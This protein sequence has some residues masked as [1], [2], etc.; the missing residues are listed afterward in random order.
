MFIVM[1]IAYVYNYNVLFSCFLVILNKSK[2]PRFFFIYKTILRFIFHLPIY[3]VT[4][5]F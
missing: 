3:S 2:V 5:I 4:V 1:H